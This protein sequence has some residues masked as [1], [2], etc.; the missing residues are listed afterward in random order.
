MLSGDRRFEAGW[1][2][3]FYYN[4]RGN[5]R[6]KEKGETQRGKARGKGERRRGKGEGVA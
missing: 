6:A 5:I 2:S 4:P 3:I 1:D